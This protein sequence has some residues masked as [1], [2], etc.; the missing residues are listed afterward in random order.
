M[1]ILKKKAQL[2]KGSD[3]GVLKDLDTH[4]MKKA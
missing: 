1:E 4:K 2:K 3:L